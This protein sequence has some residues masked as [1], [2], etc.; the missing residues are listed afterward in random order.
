MAELESVLPPC[1]LCL[2]PCLKP[3][4][5]DCTH[6]VLAA[7]VRAMLPHPFRASAST[8]AARSRGARA[9]PHARRHWPSVAAAVHAASGRARLVARWR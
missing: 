5:S 6:A 1:E 9:I 7:G 3:A 4:A 8:E 2:S